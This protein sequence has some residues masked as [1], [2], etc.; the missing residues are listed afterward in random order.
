MKNG[1]Y[2]AALVL[3]DTA[4]EKY[5]VGGPE[6]IAFIKKLKEVADDLL[7]FWDVELTE[8]QEY[9]YQA[10]WDIIKDLMQEAEEWKSASP[11]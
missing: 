1:T 11:Q 3:V 4:I 7:E 8:D 2:A 5:C 6:N 9:A 10:K